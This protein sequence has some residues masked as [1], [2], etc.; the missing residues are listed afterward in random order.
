MPAGH[1]PTHRRSSS[2][3]AASAG[4]SDFEARVAAW[5]AVAVL[6]DSAMSPRGDLSEATRFHFVQCQSS[7]D[8]DDVLVGT[9]DGGSLYIQAKRTLVASVKPESEFGKTLAQ[10]T[11]QCTTHPSTR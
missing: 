2:G 9:S 11:R 6:A 1:R 3:G 10:M 4:G 5:F 8:V 7:Q